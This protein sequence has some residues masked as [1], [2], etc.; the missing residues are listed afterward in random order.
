MRSLVDK[1]KEV[2]SFVSD[3]ARCRY[4]LEYCSPR[5]KGSHQLKIKATN[6]DNHTIFGSIT[7]SFSAEGFSGGCEIEPASHCEEDP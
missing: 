1:F 4:R 7:V 2:A 6:K 5:R 3:E